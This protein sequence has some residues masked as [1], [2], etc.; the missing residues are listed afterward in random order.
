MH[1]NVVQAARRT[2]ATLGWTTLRFNFRTAGGVPPRGQN[3]GLDLVEVY[4][5]LGARSPG[6]IDIAGY[7]YGAWA[8]MEAV[9]AGLYP[10]SLILISPPLD[11]I[12]FEELKLPPTPTLIT[13]GNRDDFCSLGALRTWLATS[14]HSDIGVEILPGVDHFYQDAERELSEKIKSFLTRLV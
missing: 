11:F 6:P 5:F 8:A 9:R 13:L 3:D 1:N 7:S 2:F 12:S 10:D 14:P 4:K